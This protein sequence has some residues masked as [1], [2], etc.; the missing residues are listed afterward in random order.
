MHVLTVAAMLVMI[1]A[2]EPGDG[3]P[4]TTPDAPPLADAALADAEPFVCS[5]GMPVA[6]AGPACLA[7]GL[8]P[9]QGRTPFGDLDLALAYFGAGDC[10]TISQA[11][12]GWVGACQEQLAV[13]FSYPVTTDGTRRRV[14]GAFDSDARVELRP[15]DDAPRTTVTKI[16]VDVTSWE[17]GMGVHTIDIT[18]TFT[19]ASFAV[20][21]MHIQGTFCDWPFYL[22]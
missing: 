7:L 5:T 1:A 17:E 14:V 22:C 21:P 2:C 10:L 11:T 8:S 19:D 16:H 15:L 3:P 4:A 6:P 9:L 12:I 18:V 20:G 13:Q